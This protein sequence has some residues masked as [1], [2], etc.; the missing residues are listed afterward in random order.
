MYQA[1]ECVCGCVVGARILRNPILTPS[2][3]C[4]R[5]SDY[6]NEEETVKWDWFYIPVTDPHLLIILSKGCSHGIFVDRLHNTNDVS[7]A[8]ADGHAKDGLRLIS[9]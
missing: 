3:K 2:M 6:N 4:P 9:C 1:L 8:V 5:W 7:I